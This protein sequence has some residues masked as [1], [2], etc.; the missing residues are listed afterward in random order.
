VVLADLARAGLGED[1]VQIAASFPSAAD[2]LPL[3]VA[4]LPSLRPDERDAVVERSIDLAVRTRAHFRA[5][6]WELLA[7]L[8]SLEQTIDA[9]ARERDVAARAPADHPYFAGQ[10]LGPLLV[11]L[12]RC[13]E[14][15]AALRLALELDEVTSRALVLA[16]L[17]VHAPADRRHELVAWV[18]AQ[19]RTADDQAWLDVVNDASGPLGPMLQPFYMVAVEQ[20]PQWSESLVRS[21]APAIEPAD[22]ESW[23]KELVERAPTG[24]AAAA[25][26]L[27]GRHVEASLRDE[28]AHRVW[29]RC[30]SREQGLPV[31]ASRSLLRAELSTGRRDAIATALMELNETAWSDFGP[32][33]TS[34]LTAMPRA[35]AG[36]LDR[37]A[38]GRVDTRND[39]L[40]AIADVLPAEDLDRALR[41]AS[42]NDDEDERVLART[43]LAAE[44]SDEE[45]IG[46]VL[47]EV[48]R[49]VREGRMSYV[50]S[51]VLARL[52]P[53]LPDELVPAAMRLFGELDWVTSIAEAAAPAL[54]RRT[55]DT[56]ILDRALEAIETAEDSTR[57]G[58]ALAAIHPHL[59]A[60]HRQRARAWLLAPR[61][62]S[63]GARRV[64]SAIE[65][66]LELAG[67]EEVAGA[68]VD[69]VESVAPKDQLDPLRRSVW[70]LPPRARARAEAIFSGIAGRSD[71]AIALC[72]ELGRAGT[73]AS[74]ELVRRLAGLVADLVQRPESGDGVFP[75]DI[76]LSRALPLFPDTQLALDAILSL[77]DPWRRGEALE[78][79]APRLEPGK[80]IQRAIDGARLT[81]P[82]RVR[83]GALRAL[84]RRLRT[85]SPGAAL[86]VLHDA[87]RAS[88]EEKEAAWL[89]R[90]TAACAQSLVESGPAAV[91]EACRGL[92]TAMV[93]FSRAHVLGKIFSAA[94]LLPGGFSRASLRDTFD[95]IG[96]VG[97]FWP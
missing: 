10:C 94:P 40:A 24:A 59:S 63:D 1:V 44:L 86:A 6:Q 92:T 20:A 69:A 49:A 87:F 71:L 74:P 36:I 50:R 13:G 7:P 79:L 56:R 57:A 54:F 84:A 72:G 21:L 60:E 46:Q 88:L 18:Q 30:S 19:L 64:I 33:A 34:V 65:P 32:I 97:R 17:A 15:H 4:A 31:G 91:A 38:A 62:E 11:Q 29:L 78:E 90:E 37:I 76:V 42:V 93:Q 81:G 28:L 9:I 51:E 8:L 2:E 58:A 95:A 66:V 82:P 14:S 16:E 85:E 67:D 35:S 75:L 77:D 52:A 39:R 3:L 61:P 73:Q 23:L 41:I 5:S 83:A 45:A 96:D 43:A 55:R 70:R 47:A 68:F 89:D 27:L 12:A 80:R 22:V 25:I 48:E 26:E 53:S